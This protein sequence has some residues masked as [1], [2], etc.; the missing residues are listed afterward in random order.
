VPGPPPCSDSDELQLETTFH[1]LPTP[2][3]TFFC[4]VDLHAI[5][6][7]HEPR[8]L[9]DSTHSSAALYL[10]CGIDPAKAS[11]FVQSHVPAHA[12]LTWLLRWVLHAVHACG[13]QHPRAV[14][15]LS[16]C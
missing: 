13:V 4:V 10:A 15:G 5:T 12:E 8:A 9:L 11:I 14:T 7:P 3:D 1:C 6:M 16:P 2:T